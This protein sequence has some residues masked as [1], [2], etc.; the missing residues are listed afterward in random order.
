MTSSRSAAIRSIKAL[1]RV[2]FEA[3]DDDV[4]VVNE[5]DAWSIGTRLSDR[6]QGSPHATPC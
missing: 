6:R 1:A 2:L 3:N 5:F 4:V